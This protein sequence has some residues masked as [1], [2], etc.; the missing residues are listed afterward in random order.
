MIG[1][2][3]TLYTFPLRSFKYHCQFFPSL[4]LDETEGYV[5]K[6]LYHVTYLT[7]SHSQLSV[8][9]VSWKRF[10]Q[11]VRTSNRHAVREIELHSI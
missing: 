10:L 5:V 7:F 1:K 4:D 2:L 11:S 9:I 6:V 8:H 3:I